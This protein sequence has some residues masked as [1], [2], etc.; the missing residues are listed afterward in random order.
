MHF[1]LHRETPQECFHLGIMNQ[2]L[3]C[4]CTPLES[5][6]VVHHLNQ[7]DSNVKP[8]LQGKLFL[9]GDHP[10]FDPKTN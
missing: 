4:F 1:M 2:F 6:N 10:R 9:S 7:A 5:S 3:K 8:T